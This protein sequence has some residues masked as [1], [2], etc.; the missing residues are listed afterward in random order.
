MQ[1][2]AAGTNWKAASIF[3]C[4]HASKTTPLQVTDGCTYSSIEEHVW[5]RAKASELEKCQSTVQMT[6]CGGGGQTPMK[7]LAIFHGVKESSCHLLKQYN[8]TDVL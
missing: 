6:L 7:S 2:N 4:E 3:N 8:I 5:V 1:G